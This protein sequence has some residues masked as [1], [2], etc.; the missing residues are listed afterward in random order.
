MTALE[1]QLECDLATIEQKCGGQ[2][3]H[4]FTGLRSAALESLRVADLE[5][6]D[7]A[8]RRIHR[9]ATKVRRT[10]C[11]TLKDVREC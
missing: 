1:S 10:G 6:R 5:F 2:V 7:S 8:T 9:L 3:V 11:V 4:A